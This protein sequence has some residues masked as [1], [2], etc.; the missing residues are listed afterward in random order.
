MAEAGAIIEATGLQERIAEFFAPLADEFGL[1]ANIIYRFIGLYRTIARSQE[2]ISIETVRALLTIVMSN[3]VDPEEGGILEDF[4]FD[5]IYRQFLQLASGQV[6][7]DQIFANEREITVAMMQQTARVGEVGYQ[8]Q[9]PEEAQD[10][11]PRIARMREEFMPAGAERLRNVPENFA[12]IFY[13]D[14]FNFRAPDFLYYMLNSPL[15]SLLSFAVMRRLANVSQYAYRTMFG[16][17]AGPAA[18]A[19]VLGELFKA[20]FQKSV[21]EATIAVMSQ[22]FSKTEVDNVKT[23]LEANITEPENKELKTETKHIVEM[24]STRVPGIKQ[25]EK[26]MMGNFEAPVYEGNFD[27]QP[28]SR[29]LFNMASGADLEPFDPPEYFLETAARR[30][31]EFFGYGKAKRESGETIFHVTNPETGYVNTY[32]KHGPG[33]YISHATRG[34]DGEYIPGDLITEEEY[35]EIKEAEKMGQEPELIVNPAF[36]EPYIPKPPLPPFQP[37]KLYSQHNFGDPTFRSIRRQRYDLSDRK[38]P[39]FDLHKTKFDGLYRPYPVYEKRIKQDGHKIKLRKEDHMAGTGPV[40]KPF[41]P[42]KK[43]YSSSAKN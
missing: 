29:G 4:N 14:F 1:S 5:S 36:I 27:P 11:Y 43:A 10:L 41:E 16:N 15:R 6:T 42:L 28:S 37:P 31:S 24:A 12:L 38:I 2:P 32:I 33:G 7:L 18:I 23:M 3:A 40:Y 8:P 26:S 22:Y 39:N 21:T 30:T 20:Y 25:T 35:E 19:F 34:S 17:R 13:N 9:N